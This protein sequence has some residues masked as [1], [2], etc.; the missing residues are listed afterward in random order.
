MGRKRHASDEEKQLAK[1]AAKLIRGEPRERRAAIQV[2]HV[3]DK[4]SSMPHNVHEVF[5]M[6]WQEN[7]REGFVEGSKNVVFSVNYKIEG[8]QAQESIGDQQY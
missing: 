4:R 8:R 1:T 2:A 7:V 3:Y 6:L 5:R